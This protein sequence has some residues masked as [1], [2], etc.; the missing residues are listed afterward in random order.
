MALWIALL[1]VDI[2]LLVDAFAGFGIAN[3]FKLGLRRDVLLKIAAGASALARLE[4]GAVPIDDLAVVSLARGVG[5]AIV[6][7]SLLRSGNGPGAALF[8][9]SPVEPCRSGSG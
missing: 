7:G 8:R 4:F 5:A 6:H 3:P 2:V 1:V 9:G